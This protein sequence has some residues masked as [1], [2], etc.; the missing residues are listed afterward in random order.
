MNLKAGFWTLNAPQLRLARVIDRP[1]LAVDRY[2]LGHLAVF[3]TAAQVTNGCYLVEVSSTPVIAGVGILG[4]ARVPDSEDVPI[5]VPSAAALSAGHYLRMESLGGPIPHDE[6]LH[7]Y[8]LSPERGVISGRGFRLEFAA[9][10]AGWPANARGLIDAAGAPL[11]SV[12]VD[13][14]WV[15]KLLDAVTTIHRVA[16]T[17]GGSFAA[18]GIRLL[19]RDRAE[20]ITL[21]AQ[22]LEGA[23]RVRAALMPR[24]D[25]D[26]IVPE[27]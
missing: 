25:R 8:L 11:A 10:L 5:L 1:Q 2:D 9:G 19:V 27:H 6:L 21:E 23:P 20:A 15:S 17:S 3:A 13:A 24:R 18:R 14:M 12:T 16:G 22:K 7:V 4:E 26:G